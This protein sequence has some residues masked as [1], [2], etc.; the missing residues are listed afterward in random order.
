[1]KEK[2]AIIGLYEKYKCALSRFFFS[3]PPSWPQK[4]GLK[5]QEG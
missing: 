2:I 1:M 3:S 5:R 4:K